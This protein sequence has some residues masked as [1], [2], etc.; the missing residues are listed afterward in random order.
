MDVESVIDLV[1][2]VLGESQLS[3]LQLKVL[4]QVWIERSYQEIATSVGYEVGYIKQTGSQLWR[5]LSQAFGVK[6][7]KSNA[8]SIL[9]RK[10]R[11]VLESETIPPL[12]IKSEPA[13]EVATDWGEAVDV[14]SFQ[15]RTTELDCLEGWIERDRCRLIGIFG[16]GGIGK[17]SLSVKVAQRLESRFDV[18][19]WRSLRNAPT[20]EVLL[21]DILAVLSSSTPT[22]VSA[23]LK[24][25][26]L[27]LL[28]HLRVRRCLLVLDNIETV[29]RS[30]D[31]Q[32]DYQKG[33]GGYGQLLGCLGD[34][35]H[36][37]TIILT[38]REKPK[39]F[40]L[41]EGMDWPI[42]S[43]TL[44]GLS[45]GSMRAILQEK[46]YFTGSQIAWKALNA[47][48]AG[49]PLALKMVASVVR[50][51]F[52]GNLDTFLD[53]LKNESCV[54]GDLRN[55]LDEQV[56]R[57]SDLECQ[58]IYW[59]AIEREP[60]SLKT[61]WDNLH[62]R[63]T[64]TAVI[65]V[66]TALERRSLIETILPPTGEQSPLG[67]SDCSPQFTLQP[68]VMEFITERLIDEFCNIFDR[69][70]AESNSAQPSDAPV[71]SSF[72]FGLF[73]SHALMK[74][75]A[76]D[77]IREAQV[78]FILQ[79]ILKRLQ[80]CYANKKLLGYFQAILVT[81][82]R[83]LPRASGYVAGNLLNLL[84][85]IS[86]RLQDWDFSELAVWQAYLVR[87]HL[88]RFNF[89]GAD[90]AQSV[91]TQ[92]C[93]QILS[94]AFSPDDR[95]LVAGD[96]NHELHVWQVADGKRCFSCRIDEG[97][98]WSVAFSPDG[99]SIAS[100]ANRAVYLWDATTGKCIR[101]FEG[102][103]DRVFAVAFSP[104]GDWLATG[105]EDGMVRVWSVGTG[106]LLRV[107][108]GHTGEVRSVAFV[109]LSCKHPSLES[110]LVS[111]SIDGTIRLWDVLSGLEIGCLG[112]G[113]TPIWSIALSPDGTMLAASSSDHAIRLWSLPS[114]DSIA[115]FQGHQ[116]RSQSIAFSPDSKT[117]A[118]GSDDSTIR[119]WH[120]ET[121]RCLRVLQGHG[122]WIS[123]IA[124]SPQG[125]LLA[126]GSE[127][128]SVRLW[129]K[130]TRYCLKTFQGYSN[131]IW[132]IVGNTDGT[133]LASGSQDRTIRLWDS[134]S[135]EPVRCLNGHTS[136]VWTLA[137]SPDG[138]TL[139]SGSEDKSI[140]LWDSTTGD[141]RNTLSGHT[142]PVYSVIFG[143]DGK[144]L[145]SC[146]LD[147]TIKC[148]EVDSGQCLRTFLGHDASIWALA[149]SRDGRM[150][151]SCSLDSTIK[152]WDVSMGLCQKTFSDSARWV[153]C[154]DI[155]PIHLIMVSGS[156]DGH[157]KLWDLN[158]S[159]S[160]HAAFAAHCGPVLAVAF[161]PDGKT[162][163]SCGADRL[164]KLWDSETLRCLQVF[165]GHSRW[166]R[167]VAYSADGRTLMS[168][169][170]DETI[171]LWQVDTGQC[172]RILQ[173]PRPYEGT[174]IDRATGLTTLQKENLKQ[175]G[176]VE[177]L[178]L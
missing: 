86:D 4:E 110:T 84:A 94:L 122:S 156:A 75:Q 103:N 160:P 73:A 65:E 167:S 9:S 18:I 3:K 159:A 154:C 30:G 111:G 54:F 151:A 44:T 67:G 49:N 139:A 169:G 114:G 131:G 45:P 26:L 43:L 175:L 163:A 39:G 22:P 60:I 79:P 92:T 102:F 135:G 7:T 99:L 71:A 174:Q 109:P 168:C 158:C 48:Y 35:P 164:I 137:Y 112:H 80:A 25:Q 20:T 42:R 91:F 74:A 2:K 19:V 126:S 90:L 46:G 55:L 178:L 161:A 150:L 124:F 176:V 23:P 146:S 69:F 59:L 171:R 16:M 5:S 149:L 118:S 11:E 155:S 47:R 37:S 104:E 121:K 82:R 89:Q 57:L 63:C 106:E 12:I 162:F 87:H 108:A 14:T 107:L 13:K 32:G 129:D 123:A 113:K 166:V 153:R 116:A 100:G 142:G 143:T 136:W 15:G 165:S 83:Q 61:L 117:L 64:L 56:R 95:Y 41:R 78:K 85:Q 145:Y 148:W 17:T 76:R 66:L 128:Q 133:Q 88:Y 120:V 40:A 28:N 24:D 81:L 8:Q 36:Q 62:P 141:L 173:S 132:C 29:L 134:V 177:K 93:G 33:Y 130:Q 127:D 115:T 31:L 157:L 1:E 70:V 68:V 147:G 101:R 34:T 58:S 98:I 53:M 38:S 6:I 51:C 97:W 152:I 10:V 96:I 125:G 21:A 27:Q 72:S 140:K 105:S 138:S 144:F 50:D 52:A 119:I 77:Y 172:G 170:Q